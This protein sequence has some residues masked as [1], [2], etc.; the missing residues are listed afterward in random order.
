[1]G[2]PTGNVWCPELVTFKPCA[3]YERPNTAMPIRF[4]RQRR[5]H[6]KGLR[7]SQGK[8]RQ[9]KAS[10]GV[11]H[12]QIGRWVGRR[13]WKTNRNSWPST[14]TERMVRKGHATNVA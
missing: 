6:G 7:V 8:A 4:R 2:T 10:E 9:G 3:R 5:N 12:R 1:M 11:T 14:I 13:K